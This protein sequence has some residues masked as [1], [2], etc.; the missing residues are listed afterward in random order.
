M[1]QIF[2]FFIFFGF[3]GHFSGKI[4]PKISPKI[5]KKLLKKIGIKIQNSVPQFFRYCSYKSNK[6]NRIKISLKL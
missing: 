6:E 3:Y 4:L 1:E 2:E 5:L